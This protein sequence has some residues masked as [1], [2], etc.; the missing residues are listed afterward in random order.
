M[1]MV[2]EKVEKPLK[3]VTLRFPPDLHKK[4]KLVSV[5]EGKTMS[6]LVVLWVSEK[7]KTLEKRR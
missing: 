5:N 6:D 1:K 3:Q 7:L 2:K 4:L